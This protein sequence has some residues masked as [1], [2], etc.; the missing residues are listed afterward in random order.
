MDL[1]LKGKTAVVTGGGG[2][3]CGA[4]TRGL[5]AEGVSVAI[6]DISPEAA[7][8][9]AECIS[10]ELETFPGAVL[11]AVE[12]DVLD[13]RG[14]QRA[15]DKTL[16]AFGTVDILVNGAGGSRK[17]ATTSDGLTFFDLA[18]EDLKK[19]FDLN[20]MS[21]II[22]SRE[23]GRIFAEKRAGIILNIS[24]IAGM[25]P[26]TRA[27]SYSNG[28]AAVN[29]FTRWLAVYM[30]QTF[31]PAIRVNAVAPGFI[32]T[33]QNRF[34]LEDPVTKDLTERGKRIL[35]HVPMARLGTPEEIAGAALWL[36]SEQASFVT[37]AVIPVDGGFTAFA[38]V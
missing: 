32:L 17:E 31:S 26:L 16:G 13:D 9:K 34:L 23:I 24:S 18:L 22:P 25:R 14:V 38:G 7:R 27:V 4:I 3:I 2:A 33:E 11:T 37:G 10:K 29:S 5:A 30:A 12:C 21:V 8:K 19:V 36:V 6:W 20:Y 15:L 35:A 1:K 28:K